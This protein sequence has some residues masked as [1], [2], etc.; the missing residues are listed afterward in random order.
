[1]TTIVATW[2]PPGFAS[3]Q[4]LLLSPLSKV[5]MMEL[6]PLAQKLA[7]VICATSWPT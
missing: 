6:L 4:P 2:P 3:Q 5:M 7:W 1:V